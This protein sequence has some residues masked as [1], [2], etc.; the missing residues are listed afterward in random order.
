M[1]SINTL[2]LVSAVNAWLANTPQPRICTSLT[3]PLSAAW[4]K[5]A[6]GGQA[7]YISHKFLEALLFEDQVQIQ[8]PVESIVAAGETSRADA[9]HAFVST[10][11]ACAGIAH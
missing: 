3:A 4:L 7:S 1:K 6:G 9:M 10:M 8:G 5:A 2:S 11:H